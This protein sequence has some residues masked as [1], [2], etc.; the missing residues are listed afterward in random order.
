MNELNEGVGFEDI[1]SERYRPCPLS[2]SEIERACV[3]SE[4]GTNKTS[5]IKLA[6]KVKPLDWIAKY[7]GLV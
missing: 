7:L 5:R 3:S 4:F 6:C 2:G 1:N